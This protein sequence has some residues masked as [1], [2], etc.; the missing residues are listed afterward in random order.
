[1][2]DGRPVS[3]GH[4]LGGEH[5]MGNWGEVKAQAAQMLGIQLLDADVFNV[6]LLATDRYGA[7]LR[8]PNGFALIAT[9]TGY[10]EGDPT[11]NGGLGVALPPNTF[12]TGHAFLDDIAHSAV[13]GTW[14]HDNNPATAPVARTADS[15]TVTGGVPNPGFDPSQPITA[16]NQMFLPQ[17]A[18]TYDNELLDRHFITG[19]GRGNENIGLSA[20][21]AIFHSEHDRLVEQYKE[22]LLGSGDLAVLNEWLRTP[23]DAIPATLEAIAALQ[24]DGERLF[25]AGRFANEMQYQHLVF[26]E[27]ARAVQPGV[28]PFVFSHSPDLNPAIFEEFAN[29]VYRFGHSMLTET[30]ARLDGD[31]NNQDIGLIKAFLNPVEFN[32]DGATSH[33][34]AIGAI[35]RGMS[36]QVGNEIDEFVTEALRNNLVGLPLDLATLNMARARETGAP[37]F[38]EARKVFY[39]MT[40]DSQLEPYTSWTDM[41][42]HLKN[43]MS[44]I[45]FIA[46]Y[47]KHESI[48]SETTLAGKRAA[49]TVM[50]MGDIDLTG[51]GV[52]TQAPADRLDFLTSRGAWNAANSGLN[53]IDFWIGGLAEAKLAFGGMLGPTFN[54]VFEAQMRWAKHGVS[55]LLLTR[56]KINR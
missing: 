5:G 29:V 1:M 24:W 39:E 33:A 17:P 45:N 52:I 23:V 36:R 13:P 19:D 21:H 44:I 40:G 35:V 56:F 55:A 11:A 2:V 54:F 51:D 50:V 27:F 30:V 18:G 41:A 8:G 43:P 38:N 6:P 31:L 26:E 10:V 37:T 49:A 47:G 15:D 3:T 32:Q 16:N 28:D 34:E 46:A 22:T 4:L 42:P 20:I 48:T 25:Q 12:R 7:F 14:D 53:D 9:A